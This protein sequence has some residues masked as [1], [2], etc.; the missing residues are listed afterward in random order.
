ML[1]KLV[2]Q[3]AVAAML[4]MVASTASAGTLLPLQSTLKMNLGALPPVTI[5]GSYQHGGWATLTS[6]GAFHDLTDIPS[7]WND[8]GVAVG[9]SLLT[10]VS[11]SSPS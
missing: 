4:C 2:A 1:R 5:A 6:N 8:S 9:T 10:G 7:I 3:I 11:R